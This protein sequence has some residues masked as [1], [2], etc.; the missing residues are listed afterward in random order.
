MI[1]QPVDFITLKI[2]SYAGVA[3]RIDRLSKGREQKI[4][5]RVGT[6]N[7]LRFLKWYIIRSTPNRVKVVFCDSFFGCDIRYNLILEKQSHPRIIHYRSW[8]RQ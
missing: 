4:L 5:K 2:Y 8:F 7:R 3:Q 6:E 1:H